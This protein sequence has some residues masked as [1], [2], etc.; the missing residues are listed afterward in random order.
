MASEHVAIA[1]TELATD[2]QRLVSLV[3]RSR[4]EEARLLARQLA[5]RWPESGEVAYWA[6]VLVPPRA[7]T[8]A[9]ERTRTFGREF[10]WLRKHAHEYPGCWL[11]VSGDQ[12]VAA[13]TDRVE[14]IQR[15]KRAGVENEALLYFQPAVEY[16]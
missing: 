12:L 14:V 3:E 8:A 6:R 16:R 5:D 2:L 4:V 15:V 1:Q 7:S 9:D 13:S 10:S 11:A